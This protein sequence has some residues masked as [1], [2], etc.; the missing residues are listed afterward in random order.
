MAKFAV[1]ESCAWRSEYA[2]TSMAKAVKATDGWLFKEEPSHYSYDDF[3]KD[4]T[5]LWPG[6][7]NSLARQH[8]KKAKVGD[9]VLYYHTGRE[10]AVV[11]EMVVIEGPMADPSTTDAKAVVLRVRAVKKWPRPVTLTQIKQERRLAEWELVKNSRLSVM[12]VSAEQ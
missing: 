8:L 10:K 5:T 12:P 9:R 4:G 2:V 6:V 11:G 7:N 3:E 1:N